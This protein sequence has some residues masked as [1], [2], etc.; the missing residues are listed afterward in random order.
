MRSFLLFLAIVSLAFAQ[1]SGI[2]GSWSG[3]SLCATGAASCHD[4]KVV[5]SI[6]DVAGRTDVVIIRADKIVEG[7][8]VTMG[9]GP[10]Q[11][12]RSRHTLQWKLPRQTWLL[13]IDGNKITGTL[14]MQ[15]GTVFRRMALSREQ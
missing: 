15:D 11:Y 3:E 14:T 9:S 4:E 12:D 2:A 10:W 8:A 7:K 6:Q 5:Y 1:P 13:T